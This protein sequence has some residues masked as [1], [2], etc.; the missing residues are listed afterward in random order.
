MVL[1]CPTPYAAIAMLG[2][3][4]SSASVAGGGAPERDAIGTGSV[5]GRREGTS[6]RREGTSELAQLLAYSPSERSERARSRDGAMSGN[7]QLVATSADASSFLGHTSV[8]DEIAH[9][10][11]PG[12][13]LYLAS[14]VED[15]A[16]TLLQN[17]QSHGLEPL[18]VPSAACTD[19][20][21]PPPTATEAR[22]AS[23]PRRQQL[24]R[25]A[26]GQQ[27]DGPCWRA[28]SAMLW[29]SETERTHRLEGRAVHRVVLAKRC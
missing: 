8:F 19:A 2:E 5:S 7:T 13:E 28:A 16:L 14:N 3:A 22:A 17:A 29:A 11:A 20:Q 24:W 21:L 9:T 25:A 1:S 23:P 10:L 4:A 27:A 26:G 6:E 12:G 15:V 18:T